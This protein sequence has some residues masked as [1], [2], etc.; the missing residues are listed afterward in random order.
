MIKSEKMYIFKS[1]TEESIVVKNISM[2]LKISMFR[3]PEKKKIF[4]NA[5]IS[6]CE[7]AS[8]QC[9]T[10]KCMELRM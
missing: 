2:D 5:C 4:E 8:N 9:I 3:Y 7:S 1:I 6:V 10:K